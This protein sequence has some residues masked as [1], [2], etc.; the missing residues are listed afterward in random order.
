MSTRIE[1][2]P[3]DTKKS[4]AGETTAGSDYTQRLVRMRFAWWKQVLNVQ[5]PYRWNVR[6]MHLG[7]TLDVGCGIGRNLEHLGAGA[8]GVDHNAASIA[9]ARSRGLTAFTCEEFAR[10]PHAVPQS[11]DSLLFA[12]VL[13]HVGDDYAV[14][15]VKEYLAYLKPGGRV[16][17]ITPQERGFRSDAT[18]VTFVGFEGQRRIAAAV[19]LEMVRQYSFPLPRVA[20]KLF[21]GNEFVAV[22]RHP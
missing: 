10:S 21:V 22:T 19:G 15:L 11:Y 1:A 4:C 3:I 20:G 5:A 18:H 12:H 8:V 13:E 9:V 6:R 17:L 16:V 7:H 2:R 14:H